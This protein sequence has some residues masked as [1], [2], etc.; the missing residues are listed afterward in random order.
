MKTLLISDVHIGYKYSRA[1]DA[2]KVLDNVKFD[3]LIMIG[4]IFD[5]S[6][7][8]SGRSYWDEHHTVFLKKVFKIAKTKEVIYVAGNHDFPLKYL[9]EYTSK[10]AGIHVCRKYTYVSGDKT[11]T[12]VHGDQYENINKRIRRLGDFLYN[13]GLVMNQYIN[14]VRRSFGLDYFSFSKWCKDHVKMFISKSFNIEEKMIQDN[15][16]SDMIVFGHTHMP[17]VEDRTANTGSFVEIATYITEKNGKLK[18][19]NLDE[20]VNDER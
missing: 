10:I 6:N 3:R 9:E 17:Y 5:V 12:C 8:M 2:V 15:A 13:I 18:L 16:D 4:D 14:A 1:A 11:I 20:K 7:M 19:H